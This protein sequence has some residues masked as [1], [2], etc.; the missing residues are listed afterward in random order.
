MNTEGQEFGWDA[1][2]KMIAR[3]HWTTDEVEESRQRYIQWTRY[4]Y[5]CRDGKPDWGQQAEEDPDD[6]PE[7]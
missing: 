7:D 2:A 4:S 1:A 5:K 3:E 6:R